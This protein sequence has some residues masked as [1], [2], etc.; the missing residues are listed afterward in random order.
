MAVGSGSWIWQLDIEVAGHRATRG[1]PG[2]QTQ[3][4]GLDC[5]EWGQA[6]WGLKSEAYFGLSFLLNR[7]MFKLEL[8]TKCHVATK[9]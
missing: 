4:D 5:R 9:S 7:E 3:S 6:D 1:M 2:L 8:W